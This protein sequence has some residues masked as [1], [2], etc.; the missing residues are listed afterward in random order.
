[1]PLVWAPLTIWLSN[2]GS[3]APGFR[4]IHF[5][6]HWISNLFAVVLSF[7]CFTVDTQTYNW[8][9]SAGMTGG[10]MLFLV[11]I[12]HSFVPNSSSGNS[13]LLVIR[14]YQV[15]FLSGLAT[16]WYSCWT[17]YQDFGPLVLTT[18]FWTSHYAIYFMVVDSLGVFL[19]FWLVMLHKCPADAL[20][21]AFLT[22]VVGPGAALAIGNLR[23][24]QNE[25][26]EKQE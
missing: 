25:L 7:L 1:M 2:N 18:A 12:F 14:S 3:E 13:K 23:S 8:T 11:S 4:T 19:A 9:W 15:C 6:I 21:T 5:A 17:L 20:V 22:P 10:P 16:W 24:L 26:R